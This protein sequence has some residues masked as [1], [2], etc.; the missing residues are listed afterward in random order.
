MKASTL[1]LIPF[2][3]LATLSAAS[4]AH[5]LLQ[6]TRAPAGTPY[7]AV[8]KVEHGCDRAATM[9]ISVRIPSDFKDVKPVPKPGWNA[10]V[11]AA[12]VTWTAASTDAALPSSQHGDFVLAGTL[13][14]KPGTLWFK[15]L[16]TCEQGS[17]D[18]SQVPA[19][20]ISTAGLETPALP[21]EILSAHDF[22]QAQ[23]LPKV[24]GAWVRSAVPGQQ[25]TGAYMKLT[26][27]EPMQ[28][29]GVATPVAGVAQVHQM[30]MEGE[31]MRMRPAGALDL[32]AGQ[33]VELKPGG[34]YHVMLQDLKQPLAVGSAVPLTLTLRDA[35]GASHKLELKVPVLT[36]A[37]SATAMPMEGHKH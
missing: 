15:V 10:A 23:L 14:Q 27:K 19:K 9:A 2:A 29:V 36:V 4:Y 22:A 11:R 12:S 30:K 17:I 21:L 6:E 37:P 28:L 26:A 5:V 34:G 33:A 35:Q 25:G 31:V 16:Q 24:E 20:G 13:P 3:A 18:W 32:P 1:H 7:K 8:L